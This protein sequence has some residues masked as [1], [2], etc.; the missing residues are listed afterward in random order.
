MGTYWRTILG[1]TVSAHTPGWYA[2][3]TQVRHYFWHTR[4]RPLCGGLLRVRGARIADAQHRCPVC[5][6]E[7]LRVY[8]FDTLS[9]DE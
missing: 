2:T 5:E 1:H 7:L 4:A 3:H 8:E 9:I 6:Q